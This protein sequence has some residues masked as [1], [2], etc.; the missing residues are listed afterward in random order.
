MINKVVL[1]TGC[2]RDKYNSFHST[3]IYNMQTFCFLNAGSM[4]EIMP[5]FLARVECTSLSIQLASMSI[6]L[7]PQPFF[8]MSLARF[9][10]FY[11]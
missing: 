9:F 3:I 2:E 6:I 1:Q 8:L 5:S 7:F 4:Y 10:E 11:C